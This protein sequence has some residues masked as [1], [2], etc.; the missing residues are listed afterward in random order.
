MPNRHNS[1][2]QHR[3]NSGAVQKTGSARNYVLNKI[4]SYPL[5]MFAKSWCPYCTRAKQVIESVGRTISDYRGINIT[6]IDQMEAFGE[7]M[8]Q[9]LKRLTGSRTVPYIYIGGR[10][11]GGCSEVTQLK[12]SGELHGMMVAALK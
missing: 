4:H 7:A 3:H 9:A 10:Y 6:N 5:V 11:V 8:H 1:G 12:E 2:T